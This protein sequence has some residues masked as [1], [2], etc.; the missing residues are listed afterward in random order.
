MGEA[1]EFVGGPGILGLV[2]N[3]LPESG[4]A[5]IPLPGNGEALDFGMDEF[6]PKVK[7]ARLCALLALGDE[8]L[9]RGRESGGRGLGAHG[10]GSVYH[11]RHAR[12]FGVPNP[13][14][15]PWFARDGLE[16]VE[17][18]RGRQ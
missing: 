4:E 11:R 7:Q 8:P 15:V 14:E 16:R 17:D 12:R 9:D 5:L 18:A 6:D 2:V 10:R 3:L 1:G 13:A